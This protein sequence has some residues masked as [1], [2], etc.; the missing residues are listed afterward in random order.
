MEGSNM[1]TLKVFPTL[2]A[3]AL[4]TKVASYM[5]TKA[6]LL[7]DLIAIWAHLYLLALGRFIIEGVKMLFAGITLMPGN[8]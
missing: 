7:N 5:L 1:L 2:Q 4:H 3:E 8:L 6:S